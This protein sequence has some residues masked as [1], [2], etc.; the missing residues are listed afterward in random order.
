LPLS[1]LQQ[2]ACIGYQTW[3][4]AMGRTGAHT[5]VWLAQCLEDEACL[6]RKTLGWQEKR[7]AW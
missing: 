6:D 1:I 7:S 5:N 4:G 3:M 2:R